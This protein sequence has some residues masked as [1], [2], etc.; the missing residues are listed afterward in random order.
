MAALKLL[1]SQARRHC[2]PKPSFPP[3]PYRSLSSSPNTKPNPNP[4][5]EE[6]ARPSQPVPIQTVSYS[7][8][9]KDPSTPDQQQDPPQS[10][11]P[12]PPPRRE[13]RS[14]QQET[15]PVWTREDIRY[16][17]DV[18]AISPVSYPT[19]VAPLPEDRASGEGEE[20]KEAKE[21]SEEMEKER[22]RI[23][24]DARMRRVFRVSEEQNVAVPFPML[25]KKKERI[26]KP[27]P[28]DLMEGIRQV[29]A[30]SKRNFDETIEAHVRLGIK[31]E[32]TDQIVHGSLVLPH[33]VAKVVRVAFFAEGADADEARA[34]GADI[35]GGVELIEEIASSHKFN[36]DKCFA[37]PKLV[38]R[39]NK[40]ASF[41]KERHLLPD[42]KSGTVTSDVS[43]AIKAARLGRI[44][45][46]MDKTSIV[47]VGL[48]K[49]SF[50]EES[51]R[52][53]IGAF[54]NALLL[55]KPPNLK[56]ASKYAGY[57]NSF[58]ICSTMGPGFPISMQSLSKAADHYNKVHLK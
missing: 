55:A 27:A 2:L 8:K 9:P 7:V 52:E 15:R 18:A 42:R 28:L 17:K 16:V 20:A 30:N 46:K 33:G 11:L 1:L 5:S 4:D 31:K 34:A 49:A 36:V 35:V 43:G 45:F 3:F 48:G 22:K 44:H 57:V 37:T 51:L 47:H 41:L 14:A 10:P 40:I 19:R 24:A 6:P 13:P 32:R 12:S 54:M 21:E 29:K 58:H 25:I 56:K 23:E 50:T 38:L 53:N 26:E 39:L